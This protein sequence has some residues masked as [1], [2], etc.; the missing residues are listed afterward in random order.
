MRL[1]AAAHTVAWLDIL[2]RRSKGKS[3]A[4]GLPTEGGEGTQANTHNTHTQGGGKGARAHTWR[5]HTSMRY[6][7][8][9]EMQN[10]YSSPERTTDCSK[11]HK[12]QSC[13]RYTEHTRLPCRTHG[14]DMAVRGR[15]TSALA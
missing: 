1:G 14:Q 11:R 3:L 5:W 8:N 4:E 9:A 7:L 2:G 13:N 12:P 6:T 10:G 15:P